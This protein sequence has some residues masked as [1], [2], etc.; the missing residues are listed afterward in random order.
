MLK[1]NSNPANKVDLIVFIFSSLF[2]NKIYY[3]NLH[4]PK[5]TYDTASG[6]EIERRDENGTT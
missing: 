6:K 1:V 5:V 3:L 2:V 4:L